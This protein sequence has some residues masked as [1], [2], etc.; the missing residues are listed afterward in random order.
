M[1][2]S[3]A[4]ATRGPSPAAEPIVAEPVPAV[5]TTWR[6][7]LPSPWVGVPVACYLLLSVLGVTLSSIG[8]TYLREDPGAP[9]RDQLLPAAVTRSD[10]F[11]TSSPLAL[12]VLATGRADDLNPLTAPQAFTTMLP[13]TPVSS[14][15]LADGAVLRWG[16][17]LPHEMLFAARWWLPLLLLVLG[18][19]ALLRPLTGSRW[20]G[21]FAAALI[22]FAP[23]TA[24]WSLSPLQLWGF[25]AAGTAALVR[26]AVLVGSPGSAGPARVRG[27]WRA[28]GWGLLSAWLLART[29]LQYQPWAL[30]VAPVVLALGIVPL[31]VDRAT[32]ARRAVAI[33]AVGAFSLV[34]AGAVL[35]ENRASIAATAGTVYPGHRVSTGG[36]VPVEQLFGATALADLRRYPIIEG[37][38]SELSS[39]FAVA[40]IVAVALLAIGVTYRSREHRAAVWAVLVCSA[41]W[42]AWVTISF[43]GIGRRLPLANLVPP[44]RAGTMIGYLAVLLLCLVLPGWRDRAPWRV[45][46]AVTAAAVLAA[47]YA[48][49]RMI[50]TYLPR[51]TPTQ[52]WVSLLALAAVV[53]LLVARPRWWGGYVAGSFAA[54]LLV[55]QV[56]PVLMGLGDLRGTAVADRMLA[57]GREARTDGTLWVSDDKTVDALLTASGVPALSSRQMAGP[58][59]EQWLRLDPGGAFEGV[60][61]RG[62]S[63][64]EFDWADQQQPTFAN[65]GEDQI[66]V[67][68]SPCALAE[69]F[70]ELGHVVSSTPIEEGCLTPVDGFGWG[71]VDRYVYAVSR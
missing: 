36:P 18:M 6:R 62:G 17:F 64:V 54:F 50:V 31:L 46:A 53:A 70:A 3:A 5:R 9:P 22:A 43:G 42:V 49:S 25:L 21:L 56:N 27:R 19:P 55:W 68:V 29:P 51:L 8:T 59:R 39:G 23:A 71:G 37:N 52:V 60:W 33:G 2:A 61:N 26:C 65:H 10:E 48:S 30:V 38:P 35:W 24:W 57:A 32:R 14:V 1:T 16:A 63:F 34:L 4:T 69:R 67:T 13:G 20:P 40:G 44:E 58:D 45:V 28:V 7:W 47:G 41:P 12:G 66:V 11:L 15:V